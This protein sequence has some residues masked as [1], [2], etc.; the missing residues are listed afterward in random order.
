MAAWVVLALWVFGNGSAVP[1]AASRSGKELESSVAVHIRVDQDSRLSA[2]D[3]RSVIEEIASIWAA[4]GVRVTSGRYA[5]PLPPGGALISLRIVGEQWQRGGRTV[6]GWVTADVHEQQ[7]PTIFISNSGVRA[8]LA[9]AQF[10]HRAFTLQPVVLRDRLTAQAIGRVAAHELGHYFLQ[11]GRHQER[12]LMRP[13]YLT[14]D[15]IAPSLKPFEIPA[16]GR[17][18]LRLQVGRL[19]ELQARR[20]STDN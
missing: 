3:L 17:V 15:L 16:T 5:D 11:S 9:K 10:G 20:R 8:L 1:P 2:H 6:L 18:A 13:T 12:G 7:V 14:T 19:A 4:A